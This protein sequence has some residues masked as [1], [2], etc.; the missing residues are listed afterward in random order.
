MNNISY[1]SVSD[2]NAFPSETSI[3]SLRNCSIGS[4][5]LSRLAHPLAEC[6]LLHPC[7][8]KNEIQPIALHALAIQA[9][10]DET[11][12]GARMLS[13][14]QSL[15][16]RTLNALA[17]LAEGRVWRLPT[18][19]TLAFPVHEPPAHVLFYH[20]FVSE[21]FPLPALAGVRI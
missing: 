11:A 17:E 8:S 19:R 9:R 14:S 5:S 2:G 16:N 6:P 15:A 3:E 21:K 10:L 1:L 4:S 7:S 20:F 12:H 13:G 18:F